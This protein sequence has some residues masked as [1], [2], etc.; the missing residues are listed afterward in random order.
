MKSKKRIR[1]M[2]ISAIVAI[3]LGYLIYSSFGSSLVRY[4]TV[5][6][7][8]DNQ[9]LAGKQVKIAGKVVKGSLDKSK[10]EVRY[11]F[12]I[13]DG[14]A[15]MPVVY[16]KALPTSFKEGSEVI[17]EGTYEPDTDFKAKML[18]VKCPSKYKPKAT[19]KSEG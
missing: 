15:K 19:K 14:K 16:E 3:L 9:S 13:T 5:S 2:V 1:I 11:A 17:V 18:L 4:R 10:T 12:E 6:E 8:V 7:V